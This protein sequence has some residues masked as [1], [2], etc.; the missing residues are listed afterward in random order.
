ME[1]VL[2]EHTAWLKRQFSKPMRSATH[3][4]DI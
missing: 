3:V 4:E 2:K 1:L